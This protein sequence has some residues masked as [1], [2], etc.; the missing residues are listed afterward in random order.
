MRKTLICKVETLQKFTQYLL[1]GYPYYV[2]LSQNINMLTRYHVPY[3]LEEK[4]VKRKPYEYMDIV[5]VLKY[6]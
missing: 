2:R 1:H 4:G 5:H 6:A 3:G